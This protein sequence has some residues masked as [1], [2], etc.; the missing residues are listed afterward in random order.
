[1]SGTQPSHQ[2]D[3][4]SW[5]AN[6][7]NNAI[8]LVGILVLLAIAAEIYHYLLKDIITGRSHFL[9]YLALWLFTA[10]LVL[11]H[12]YKTVSR[13]FLPDYFFGRTFTG[14]GLLGDPIDIAIN[15]K[16]E[17]LVAA[18][19][20]AGWSSAAPLNLS[21]SVKMVYAAVAGANYPDAPVSPLF[22]FG[23][24]QD[25]AFEKDIGGNPRKRHHIRLWKTPD[26]W[27]LPGGYQADWLGAATFDSNVE[28]SLFTGQ[29]T[30]KVD[31]NVDLERDFVIKTL[32]EAKMVA[33]VDFVQH[34]TSSYHSR[35]GGGNM[36]HTD[37][38]LPFV[39]LR[40]KK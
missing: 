21:S 28:L 12:L 6:H 39:T 14:D 24:K 5:Y 40:L 33:H 26:H 3:T 15:G 31:A 37:G 2:K 7:L 18:M 32:R 36:I 11:P 27:W 8:R 35:N 22:L 30:H 38:T 20:A 29:V 10:Y 4:T 9:A 17:A 23:R 19:E 1:M 25:L 16:E 13:F 34:F